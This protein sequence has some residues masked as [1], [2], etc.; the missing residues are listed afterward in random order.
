[1]NNFVFRRAFVPPIPCI[2]GGRGGTF[3]IRRDYL[4]VARN[5]KAHRPETGAGG[6]DRI[7]ALAQFEEL[8][9]IAAK[10][11]LLSSS[12]LAL[13]AQA[14][15]LRRATSNTIRAV[16]RATSRSLR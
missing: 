7:E 8:A 11:F 14:I 5:E 1:L 9:C 4:S 12:R 15:T 10:C 2:G 3:C 16:H 13:L 6:G